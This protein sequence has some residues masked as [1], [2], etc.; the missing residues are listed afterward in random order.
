VGWLGDGVA[1]GKAP[2][3]E[4]LLKTNPRRR[5][6]AHDIEAP[7]IVWDRLLGRFTRPSPLSS[8]CQAIWHSHIKTNSFAKF[9]R[10]VTYEQ[11][12]YRGAA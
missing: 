10:L 11:P 3:L 5:A 8:S 9:Q 4:R 7:V 12:C 6:L 1:T 2:Q